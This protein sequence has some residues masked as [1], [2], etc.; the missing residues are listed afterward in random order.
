MT[1]V[2]LPEF[3]FP[4]PLGMPFGT[5]SNSGSNSSAPFTTTTSVLAWMGIA[6]QD[7][8]ITDIAFL[9]GTVTS[10]PVVDVRIETIDAR[11]GTAV[12]RTTVTKP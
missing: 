11:C 7:L 6:P 1:M 8:T 2:T 4:S 3:H 12:P 10:A 5:N 9:T